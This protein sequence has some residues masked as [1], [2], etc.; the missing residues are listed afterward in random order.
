MIALPTSSRGGFAEDWT[1]VFSMPKIFACTWWK[2][3]EDQQA[4]FS[5]IERYMLD[6]Y[7]YNYIYMVEWTYWYYWYLQCAG[8]GRYVQV[9]RW[10]DG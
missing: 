8:A 7:I 3:R 10:M 2:L 1:M 4:G 5:H 9:D 6:I